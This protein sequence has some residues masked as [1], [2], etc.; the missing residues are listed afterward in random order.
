MKI[1]EIP[2][3]TPLEHVG[4]TGGMSYDRKNSNYAKVG[5]TIKNAKHFPVFEH[6]TTSFDLIDVSR[7]FL[8]ELSKNRTIAITA[9]S[10]RRIIP[11]GPINSFS[12][13]PLTSRLFDAYYKARETYKKENARFLLPFSVKNS[14]SLSMNFREMNRLIDYIDTFNNTE[15]KEISSYFTSYLTKYNCKFL[16]EFP[17]NFKSYNWLDYVSTDFDSIKVLS[18]TPYNWTVALNIPLA[19]WMQIIRHRTLDIIYEEVLP[20]YDPI[21]TRNIDPAILDS[22]PKDDPYYYLG[23]QMVVGVLSGLPMYWE[24]LINHRTVRGAQKQTRLLAKEIK[25]TL[26]I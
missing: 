22:I 5:L 18:K 17:T 3:Q 10:L 26:F 16:E 25:A 15:F 21:V 19:I 14:L 6:V 1:T 12:S 13:C 4:Y 11:S 7:F 9:H 8:H 20:E 23:G 24:H 2:T